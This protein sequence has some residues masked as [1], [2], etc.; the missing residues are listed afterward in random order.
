M[1]EPFQCADRLKRLKTAIIKG[2]NRGGRKE[3]G[4]L[5]MPIYEYECKAC[6][7]KFEMRRS[8]GDSDKEV[9]CPRCGAEHPQR[10]LS[11]FATGSSSGACAPPSPA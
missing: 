3:R 2:V 7:E 9:R 6:G 11:L 5:A 1:A 8:L 10:V 4:S